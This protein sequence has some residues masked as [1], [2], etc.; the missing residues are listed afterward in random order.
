MSAEPPSGAAPLGVLRRFLAP[1]EAPRAS[2]VCEMCAAAVPAEHGHVVNVE[3][4]RLVCACR[5]CFLLFAPRGAAGGKYRAVGDRTLAL[6]AVGLTPAQWDAL[7][8][9]VGMA[10]FF[11]NSTLG[12]V[13]AFYPGPAGATE[14][15]LPLDA[16]QALLEAH[17]LLS[18]LEPDVEAL[19][20]YGRRGEAM[21]CFL[22]PI[23]ACYELTGRV[24]RHWRGFDGGEDAHREI[25]GFF[26]ALRARSRPAGA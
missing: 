5:A 1:R 18:T 14:S 7:Q 3:T 8:V 11:F 26:D 10:F 2:E 20:V 4:R 22:V 17:P 24:R 6:G 25:D 13:V 12:K 9:P 16:W 15:E 19:L 23:D 21:E